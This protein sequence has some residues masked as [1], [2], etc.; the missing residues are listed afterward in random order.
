MSGEPP[1]KSARME[2]QRLSMGTHS[3]AFQA[4]EALGIWML[5]QLPKWRDATLTRSRDP[6]VLEPLDIVIDVGGLY[7][8]AKL[9]YDHHQRGFFETFDGALGP[10]GG[11]DVDR[12]ATGPESATGAFKTKLSASGLVYKHYGEELLCALHPELG[13]APDARAWAYEKLYAGFMEGIDANDNGIEI[14]DAPRYREGT[15][16]PARVHRLN[17]P[18]NAPK[19]GPSEDERFERASALCGAEFADALRA[20]V[21]VELPARA[22]V[23]AALLRRRDAVHAGG[24]V[25]ALTS[26]GCPW[27]THLYELERAHG[28]APLVKFVLYEDSSGM[29]R[30]QAVTQEGTAFT[31]RVSLGAESWRGLRDDALSAE[32]G[33]PGCKF[34]HNTGFIGGNATY[35]GALAMAAKTMEQ[36]PPAAVS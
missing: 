30:V 1:S 4:D 13:G 19:G 16:L 5:R 22:V 24:E 31:N 28:V 23:E 3:G 2:F 8:H 14:A 11:G 27:K 18:W 7:E 36:Q 10:S 26:G 15:T 25:L 35:E 33:I 12:T 32:A 17:A 21:E 9:R 20:I 34:V 29:W 6:K